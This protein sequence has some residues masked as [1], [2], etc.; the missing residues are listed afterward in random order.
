MYVYFKKLF[1]LSVF[2]KATNVSLHHV[3]TFITNY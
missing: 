1:I 3:Y 2:F